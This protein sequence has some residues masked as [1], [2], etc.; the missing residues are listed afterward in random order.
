MIGQVLVHEK[1][2]LRPGNVLA[3]RFY[4]EVNGMDDTTVAALDV[5]TAFAV[6]SL[7][8][9][10]AKV[11]NLFGFG[12]RRSRLVW[13]VTQPTLDQQPCLSPFRPSTLLILRTRVF[14]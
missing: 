13:L 14:P 5:I 8:D 4:R 9:F 10:F 6:P 1:K 3:I 12:C 11:V 2:G 7:N